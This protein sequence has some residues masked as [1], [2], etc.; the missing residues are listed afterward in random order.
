MT[1]TELVRCTA[2]A[3]DEQL[4][5]TGAVVNAFLTQITMALAAGEKVQLIGCGSF[6]V[7][8]RKSRIGKNPRTGEKIEIPAYRVPTFKAGAAL[9][10]AV[11]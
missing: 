6:E 5:T 11:K 3:A 10:D 4:K 7:R 8:D 2:E 9:K 1:K